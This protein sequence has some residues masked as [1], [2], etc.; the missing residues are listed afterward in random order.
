VSSIR[1]YALPRTSEGGG[2]LPRTVRVSYRLNGLPALPPPDAGAAR[3]GA[4]PLDA[5]FPSIDGAP[6]CKC[7]PDARCDV[8]PMRRVSRC[9][10]GFENADEAVRTSHDDVVWPRAARRLYVRQLSCP[11]RLTHQ[12][13]ARPQVLRCAPCSHQT[14]KDPLPSIEMR[15]VRKTVRMP[16]DD[17]ARSRAAPE[18]RVRHLGSRSPAPRRRHARLQVVRCAPWPGLDSRRWQSVHADLLDHVGKRRTERGRVKTLKDL[19]PSIETRNVR[20]NKSPDVSSP[21]HPHE[22]VH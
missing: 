15:N 7:S 3:E 4:I 6:V 10:R 18:P 21:P 16:R 17:V 2:K 19:L 14:L 20:K 13:R 8:L 22:M 1:S 12:R 5:Q 11:P 9:V